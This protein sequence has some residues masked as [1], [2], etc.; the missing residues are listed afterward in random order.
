MRLTLVGTDIQS[1]CLAHG[2][3]RH[4]AASLLDVHTKYHLLFV[5]VEQESV[6]CLKTL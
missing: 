2:N 3:V 4:S 6:F 5:A 1:S